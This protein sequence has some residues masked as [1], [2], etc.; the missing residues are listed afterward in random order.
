[1]D[2][3]INVLAVAAILMTLLLGY[4]VVMTIYRG[5]SSRAGVGERMPMWPDCPVAWLSLQKEVALN[6]EH[7]PWSSE[8]TDTSWRDIIVSKI[9][10]ISPERPVTKSLESK[11]TLLYLPARNRGVIGWW[12]IRLT[13]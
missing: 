3:L 9:P 10:E 8:D 2:S 13:D 12:V 1:M 6:E 5:L 4:F 7:E 11:S